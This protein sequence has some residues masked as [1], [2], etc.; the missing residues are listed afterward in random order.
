MPGGVGGCCDDFEFR[1]EPAKD[2]SPEGIV[3]IS[4]SMFGWGRKRG[5]CVIDVTGSGAASRCTCGPWW[6]QCFGL[7][8]VPKIYT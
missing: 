7:R 5:L 4:E 3:K 1:F 6:A 2:V 8:G